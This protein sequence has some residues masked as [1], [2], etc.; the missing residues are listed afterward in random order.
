MR[1]LLFSGGLDS[2]ALAWWHRPDV[3]FFVDYG[4]TPAPGERAASISIASELGLNLETL[5]VDLSGLGIGPL[6]GKAPSI[7]ARGPEWWPYR[8]QM[9]LTLAGMR[10]V[11]EGLRE[12]LI[13]SVATDVHADGCAPFLR[14]IDRLMGLQE[15]GVR[16]SAPA[17]RLTGPALLRSSGIPASLLGATFSCHVMEYACG[18]CPG[19]EKHRETLRNFMA[20]GS[21][22]TVQ[23]NLRLNSHLKED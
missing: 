12:I 19:C 16:V 1:V 9:L 7:L 10:F 21:D 4:Q 15:G 5:N 13:G 11:G 20:V 6:A 17:R 8:N 22:G 23:R 18:R 3:C 14:T 2:T